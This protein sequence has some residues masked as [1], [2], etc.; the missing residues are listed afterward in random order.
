MDWLDKRIGKSME[1]PEERFYLMAMKN[2][3]GI[4][5]DV[6]K[7]IYQENPNAPTETLLDYL[8]KEKKN[9]LLIGYM[10]YI[11]I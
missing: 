10:L 2:Y 9:N 11:K 3:S 1:D 8:K 6:I 4:S 5:A 7:K